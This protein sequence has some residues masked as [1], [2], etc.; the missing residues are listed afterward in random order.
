MHFFMLCFGIISTALLSILQPMPVQASTIKYTYTALGQVSSVDGPRADVADITRYTYNAQGNLSSI[1]NALGQVTTLAKYDS[2]GRPQNA[3]DPNGV[4]T[5]LTYTPQG[6][7]ASS[8]VAGATTQYTYNAVGDITCITAPDASYLA[9]TYDDARRLVGVTN[10][11]GESFTYTLD[12]MGNQ[13]SLLTTDASGGLVRQ[14]RRAYDELGRLLT[15]V[16]ASGQIT[17]YRYDLNDQL[18]RKTDARSNVAKG[19]FD[20]LGRVTQATDALGGITALSYDLDDN[21]TQ[22]IDARGITT[23]Y[24]YDGLGRLLEARSPDKGVSKYIYDEAGNV[25]QRTD[26]KGVV[27]T[28]QY[29]ALNRLTSQLYPA[30]PALNVTYTYDQTEGGNKGVGRLTTR[31]DALGTATYHYDDRGRLVEKSRALNLSNQGSFDVLG[32]SYDKAN[33]VIRQDFPDN[34]SVVYSRNA[35][36]QVVAVSLT[37]MGQLYNVAHD[38]SYMPFG[39]IKH[40]TWNNNWVLSRTYDQDYQLLAQ[41]VGNWKTQYVYDTVGNITSKQSNLFGAKQY[42]YDVLNRLT[43]ERTAAK[44]HD[45]VFD[46]VG[47]RTE[48]T[49]TD[50]TTSTI[51]ET[52]KATIAIQSNRLD[53]VNN[54]PLLY[55]P[56]GNILQYFNGLRYVYDDSGRMTSVYHSG[57]QKVADYHYN[58]LGQ[59]VLK[60]VYGSVS[61]ALDSISSYFY[62]SDG[63]LLVQSDHNAMGLRQLARYWIW[64]DGLPL[65]Q[66]ELSFSPDAPSTLQ[67]VY[68]HP[69]HLNAPRL[70]SNQDSAVWNWNSDAYGVASPNEDVDGDSIATHVPLRLPGQLYDE[71]TQLTYNYFRDYDANLGRYVQSDPIG[72]AGGVN[73]YGYAEGNPLK[74]VDVYGLKV[75]FDN[76]AKDIHK[77][78]GMYER[79]KETDHGRKICQTLERLPET[80]T[81]TTAES[82]GSAFYEGSKR[83]VRM[84]PGFSPLIYTEEGV[85]RADPVTILGHEIGHAATKIWDDGPGRMNNINKNENPIREQLQMPR[86]TKYDLAPEGGFL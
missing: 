51:S 39:P 16:G 62:G 82:A 37:F 44:Q 76:E 23:Q 11:L 61:G 77:L 20:A 25:T 30:T 15:S 63:K 81:I 12:A 56:A 29:D 28:Y 24:T 40:L 78:R 60:Q 75:L 5:T 84:D 86:R 47:N 49:T 64:L 85:V 41:T 34:L 22:L 19:A 17:R 52:Q 71:H 7:L 27:I 9:Y 68:L 1:A 21:L 65:A 45:Y 58:G 42:E 79:L 57:S 73:T 72:L 67:V 26:A 3:I 31:K 14:Q 66:V 69:D 38:I 18:I 70:A 43:R 83:T 50:L 46:A 13:T 53:T 80:Y 32:Y 74:N 4:V 8:S 35:V 55:D 48:K 6:W 54:S 59:R 10:A 2:L 33:R 36:G